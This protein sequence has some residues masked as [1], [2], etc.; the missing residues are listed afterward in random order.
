LQ[1]DRGDRTVEFLRLLSEQERPLYAFILAMSSCWADADDIAQEVRIRLWKQFDKYQS[2]T[3]FGAWARSVAYYLVLAHRKK[4]TSDHLRFGLPFYESLRA[5]IEASPDLIDERRVALARC[6]EGL[7]KTKR[8]L[9]EQ[10]YSGK[11]SLHD[12]AARLDRSYDA[13]RKALY[14]TQ[15]ALADCIEGRLREEEEEP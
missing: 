7:D 4:A 6:L 5:E 10:Y 2:G 13:T 3:D 1:E 12:L 9:V 15:L 11:E 8:W 14:R